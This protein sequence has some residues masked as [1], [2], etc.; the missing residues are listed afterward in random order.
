MWYILKQ[1]QSGILVSCVKMWQVRG[2][3]KPS[4]NQA[5]EAAE[6]SG[7]SSSQ[8][9]ATTEPN[10]PKKRTPEE[11]EV[12][13]QETLRRRRE[14]PVS[15]VLPMPPPL[16]RAAA[17]ARGSAAGRVNCIKNTLIFGPPFCSIFT[18]ILPF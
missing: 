3:V 18:T 14:Q 13:R 4:S 9:S 2:A 1:E 15:V 7:A 17:V 16:P 11:Y 6:P 8:A 10:P 5:S 12:N